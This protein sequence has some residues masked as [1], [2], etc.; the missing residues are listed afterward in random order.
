MTSHVVG[1][2]NAL[3]GCTICYTS[4]PL[5]DSS[6]RFSPYLGYMW[7]VGAIGVVGVEADWG[8]ASRTTTFNGMFYPDSAAVTTSAN[9]TFAVKVDWDAS[10]YLKAVTPED[11]DALRQRL[12]SAYQDLRMLIKGFD[13]WQGEVVQWVALHLIG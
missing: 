9:D 1:A 6:P 8:L 12:R 13:T 2:F 5:N 10:W 4:E 3:A 7:Q 11:W